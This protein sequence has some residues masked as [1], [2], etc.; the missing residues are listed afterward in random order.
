MFRPRGQVP[1]GIDGYTN[2]S[3]ITTDV[4]SRTEDTRRQNNVEEL[5]SL[6]NFLRIRPL[7]DWERFNQEINKPVKSGKSIRAMKKLQVSD[8]ILI[9]RHVD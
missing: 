3:Q 1:L 9:L 8:Q 6:L 5:Y 2:V 7:N 4:F